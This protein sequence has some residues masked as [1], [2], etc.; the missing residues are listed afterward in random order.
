MVLYFVVDNRLVTFNDFTVDAS[1]ATYYRNC[2][3]MLG[4]Y[5][6][7][8]HIFGWLPKPEG[9]LVAQSPEKARLVNGKELNELAIGTTLEPRHSCVGSDV[10]R[11]TWGTFFVDSLNKI[12]TDIFSNGGDNERSV[13]VVCLSPDL[14]LLGDHRKNTLLSFGLDGFCETFN[15]AK[16]AYPKL[17]I[18]IITPII[19]HQDGSDHYSNPNLVH[20]LAKLKDCAAFVTFHSIVNSPL[21]YDEEIRHIVSK[22]STPILSK[23]ELPSYGGSSCSIVVRVSAASRNATNALHPGLE[24]PEIYSIVSRSQMDPRFIEGKGMQVGYPDQ[25]EA[26][27]F[28]PTVL[29]YRRSRQF[30]QNIAIIFLPL[31]VLILVNSKTK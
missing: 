3:L 20:V 27:E 12:M 2:N 10:S 9:V 5:L 8:S 19:A 21:H 22:F 14:C 26:S 13:T 18:I 17:N 29:R 31:L 25:S 4:K 24:T 16:N 23:I 1:F 28:L 11:N 30:L 7:L 6:T 15:V